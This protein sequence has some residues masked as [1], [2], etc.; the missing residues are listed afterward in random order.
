MKQRVEMRRNPRII[1]VGAVWNFGL[2][3]KKNN[4]IKYDEG[5]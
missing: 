2:Q 1:Y 5:L 4:E 3:K